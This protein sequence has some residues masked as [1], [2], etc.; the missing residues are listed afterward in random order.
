MSEFCLIV[1][2]SSP[3]CLLQ[4]LKPSLLITGHRWI[5]QIV[6]WILVINECVLDVKKDCDSSILY[7]SNGSF[8]ICIAV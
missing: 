7:F 2:V 1:L 4:H 8:N 3:H 5:H 6:W